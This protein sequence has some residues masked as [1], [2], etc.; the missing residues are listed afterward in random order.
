MI[1][2]DALALLM[3]GAGLTRGDKLIPKIRSPERCANDVERVLE[4]AVGVH[5]QSVQA[6]QLKLRCP[7]TALPST[8]AAHAVLVMQA[9]G[10]ASCEKQTRTGAGWTRADE[11]GRKRPKCPPRDGLHS[12][13][14]S[15]RAQRPCFTALSGKPRTRNVL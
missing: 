15:T 12:N 11:S 3:C 8:D 13:R 10:A 1:L 9:G 2:P 5:E 6:V 14:S 7:N 4:A